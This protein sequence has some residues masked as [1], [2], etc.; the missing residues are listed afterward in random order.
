[1]AT[2]PIPQGATLQPLQGGSVPIPEGA[3]LQP[4]STNQTQPDEQPSAL[5]RFA[6]NFGGDLV[7]AAKGVGS[8]FA[9]PQTVGDYAASI[10]GPGGLVIKRAVTGLAGAQKDQY[11]RAKQSATEGD[12]I[13]TAINSTA[14]GLPVVGPMVGGVYEQAKSGDTAG[15]AGKGASRIL[16][17]LSMAPEKSVLP[18]PAAALARGAQGIA[19]KA[20]P[21]IKRAGD[22]TFVEGT[23]AEL[24]TRAIRPP[25]TRP[26]LEAAMSDRMG[27]V[28]QKGEQIGAPVNSLANYKKAAA[29]AKAD[30]G[31]AYGD[32]VTQNAQAPI[33]TFPVR[34]AIIDSVPETDKITNPGIMPRTAKMANQFPSKMTA[35]QA[36]LVRLDTNAKLDSFFNR[37]GGDRN[38]AL[39]EPETARTAA[40]N[41][42]VRQVLYN[43]LRQRTGV[44]PEPIQNAYG[45]LEEIGNAAEKRGVVYGRQNPV[46][47]AEDFGA[48]TKGIKGFITAKL[49]KTYRNPDTIIRIAYERWAEANGIKPSWKQASG[50]KL[51]VGK[52]ARPLTLAAA[53]GAKDGN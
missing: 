49:L 10:L 36:D 50:P 40:I 27:Q 35:A 29:A 6:G 43:E 45:Q 11:D 19:G 18:N 8:L 32:L 1:M 39:S 44:N 16:Q 47:L 9:K 12:Y 25:V 7:N 17:L 23:P 42:G 38:A 30:S 46:S 24:M 15:A 41:S 4:L 22:A 2:L 34:R 31:A 21:A 37:A 51:P 48:A 3:T 53:A 52:A 20:I 13:G 28:M 33:N 14:A 5:S 26:D